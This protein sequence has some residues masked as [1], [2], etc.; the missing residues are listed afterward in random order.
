MAALCLGRPD[1]VAAMRSVGGG[2][3]QNDRSAG[4]PGLYSKHSTAAT[5]IARGGQMPIHEVS[6]VDD[7]PS[8]ALMSDAALRAWPSSQ[9]IAGSVSNQLFAQRVASMLLA[10]RFSCQ[11]RAQNTANSIEARALRWSASP[12]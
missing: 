11:A 6:D 12:R 3:A 1:S 9:H 5:S 7:A 10:A 4:V 8:V 2:P